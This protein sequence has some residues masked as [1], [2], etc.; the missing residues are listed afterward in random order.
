MDRLTSMA[1]FVMAAE[2]GSYASAAQR[3]D[4]LG[5]ALATALVIGPGLGRE[6]ETQALAAELLNRAPDAVRAH[7]SGPAQE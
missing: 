4:M 3:L 2:A 7:F 5:M 1:A 6:K